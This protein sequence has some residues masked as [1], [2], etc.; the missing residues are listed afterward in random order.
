MIIVDISPNNDH[1]SDGRNLEGDTKKRDRF[2]IHYHNVPVLSQ[3]MYK[4][5][6]KTYSFNKKE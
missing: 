1:L 6:I 5:K 3:E 4:K 2:S